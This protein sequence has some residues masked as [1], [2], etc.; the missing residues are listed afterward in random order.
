MMEKL[1]AWWGRRTVR[2][3]VGII[4]GAATGFAYYWYVGCPTG[5]CPI[6]SNPYL[7]LAMGGFLGYT[8]VA[9]GSSS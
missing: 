1:K 9:E 5:G 2:Y 4:G 7:M 8:V 6:S 3:G